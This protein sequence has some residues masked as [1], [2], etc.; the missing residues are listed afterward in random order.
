[1]GS[2]QAAAAVS[3]RAARADRADC[4]EG[5]HAH[6]PWA[7]LPHSSQQQQQAHLPHW[8]AG[9]RAGGCGSWPRG[10]ERAAGRA[11]LSAGHAAR[12]RARV[13]A[14]TRLHACS[15]H[16]PS[17]PLAASSSSMARKTC[18]RSSAFNCDS[19][20]F[21]SSARSTSSRIW[22]IVAG[23]RPRSYA[24]SSS[25]AAGAGETAASARTLRA[26]R[27]ANSRRTSHNARQSV[28]LLLRCTPH[29]TQKH[30]A[31]FVWPRRSTP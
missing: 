18:A 24:G 21:F 7:A 17:L 31:S 14:C 1:M 4:R 11:G 2:A 29:T 20:R 22:S 15:A 13:H 25:G 30:T 26:V 23:T 6:A 28:L 27:A 16:P 10:L 19:T 3:P 5:V 12:C 9:G 8:P